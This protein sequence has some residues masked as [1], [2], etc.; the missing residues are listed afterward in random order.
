[1]ALLAELRGWRGGTAAALC[2]FQPVNLLRH[3][4][5]VPASVAPHFEVSG[6]A[7]G[8]RIGFWPYAA[9]AT[10]AALLFAVLCAGCAARLRALEAREAVDELWR[11]AGGGAGWRG[12]GGQASAARVLGRGY[13]LGVAALVWLDLAVWAVLEANEE[14]PV[15]LPPASSCV[16]CA[17]FIPFYAACVAGERWAAWVLGL[18]AC[19]AAAGLEQCIAARQR[20]PDALSVEETE[21]FLDDYAVEL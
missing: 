10:A 14:T 3:A 8:V 17:V 19:G 6:L 12:A 11:G 20:P 9:A 7:A 5:H 4:R 1:V 15:R 21:R 18:F 2:L 13:W 16:P